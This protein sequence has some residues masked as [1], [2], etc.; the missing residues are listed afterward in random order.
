MIITK[1]PHRLSFCG[2]ST[3]L[4]HLYRKWGG[5][6]VGSAISLYSFL[7]V[8]PLP[9]FHD[10]KSRLV[11]SEIE[12]VKN[13]GEVR[14]RVINACLAHTGTEGGV[15]VLHSSDIPG[16]SGTG[17]S[18]SFCV[19][20]LN[21]LYAA[22]GV[23]RDPEHLARE[24]VRVEREILQE[25]VGCQDQ[26]FAALPSSPAQIIFHKDGTWTHCPLGLTSTHQRELESHL[27]M[28]FTGVARDSSRVAGSYYH[29]LE[30]EPGRHFAMVR[31]AEDCVR[32]IRDGD[33]Q[34][35]GAVVEASWRLKALASPEVSSPRLSQLLARCR[36]F[37][38]WG[39]KLMG[40]GGG[41]SLFVVAPPARHEVV[42]TQMQKEGCVH[43]PFVFSN[44]GSHIIY[45]ATQC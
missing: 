18:S 40:A 30:D 2:G 22:R 45:G 23:Y 27:L 33:F 4:P 25:N 38:A 43:L 20:L 3:D 34:K 24:A 35:M 32:A 28:F 5:L 15:E 1:T 11:Y 19:G 41:G 39:G 13:N 42:I 10:Y 8:K 6:V 14:H 17:S 21:A 26:I 36:A 29:K 44:L 16:R 12:L 31:L 7:Q 37:G 9:P